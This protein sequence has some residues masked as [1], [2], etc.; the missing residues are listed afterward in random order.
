MNWQREEDYYVEG[1]LVWL[2]ADTLIREQTHGA[3][4]LDDFARAFFGTNDGSYVVSTYHFDDIVSALNAVTPYDWAGFLH[5]RLD[6]RGGSAPLDGITR[7]GYHLVYTDQPS[8]FLTS[9]EKELEIRDFT[10]SIGLNLKK[11][12]IAGVAWGSPAFKAGLT[13]GSTIIGLN[14]NTFDDADDLAAAIREAATTH[15][16]IQMLVQTGK[17]YR[18]VEVND[19]TGLRYPHLVRTGTGPATLD[20]IIAAR[21]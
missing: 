7:G 5:A 13:M 10:F 1:L 9:F 17:H 4:S 2:D 3:K 12:T 14:G 11:S 6:R 21:H 19:T 16:P 15:A 18:L 20:A 8:G